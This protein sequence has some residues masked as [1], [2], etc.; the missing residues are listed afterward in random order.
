[1]SDSEPLEPGCGRIERLLQNGEL[2]PLRGSAANG[3]PWLK[4]ALRTYASP[5]AQTASAA[6]RA[7][8]GNASAMRSKAV[9]SWAALRNHASYADGGR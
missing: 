2:Q 1:V 4:K 6:A 7:A 9:A 5:P 3:E 8:W